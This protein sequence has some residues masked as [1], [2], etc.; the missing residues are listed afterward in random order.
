M[1][2]QNS[3]TLS[4]STKIDNNITLKINKAKHG[5]PFPAREGCV[6]CGVDGKVYIFG[7]VIQTDG[8][9]P[10]ETNELFVFDIGKFCIILFRKREQF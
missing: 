9:E 8:Q 5:F 10:K 3:Q 2:N 1:G 4:S 6:A 7:G